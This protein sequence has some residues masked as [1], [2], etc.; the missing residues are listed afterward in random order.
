M[1]KEIIRKY[2]ISWTVDFFLEYENWE[3]ASAE[4]LFAKD[5]QEKIFKKYCNDPQ[6]YNKIV[7]SYK[8]I[9]EKSPENDDFILAIYLNKQFDISISD[10]IKIYYFQ[11][12]LSMYNQ[13]LFP[14]EYPYCIETIGWRNNC[15]DHEIMADFRN[16]NY[17][18]FFKKYYLQEKKSD[19]NYECKTV[20]EMSQNSFQIEIDDHISFSF[21]QN[22]QKQSKYIAD[23][24]YYDENEILNDLINLSTMKFGI[25]YKAF[26]CP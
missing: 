16:L 10:Q 17:I 5:V 25:K 4:F 3:K 1:K 13:P 22:F 23:S 9:S 15:T 7:Q 8:T 18:K 20:E 24:W 14:W 12:R 6:P 11:N 19:W 2:P 21:F 26:W